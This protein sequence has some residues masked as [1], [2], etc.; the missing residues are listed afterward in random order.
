VVVAVI[1][2][3]VMHVTADEVVDVVAVWNRVVPAGRPVLVPG[4]VLVAVVA[5]GA[6]GGI[7]IADVYRVAFHRDT[8]VMMKLP[9]VQIVDMVAVPHRRVAA[10]RSV[11]VFMSVWGHAGPP[12]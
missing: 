7:A 3:R 8:A 1:A 10:A 11:L 2:V 6:G 4:L 9:F 5:E 12:I